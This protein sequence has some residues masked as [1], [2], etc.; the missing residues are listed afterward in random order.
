[1][2]HPSDIVER[3]EELRLFLNGEGLLGGLSFSQAPVRDGVARPY[4]WRSERLPVLTEAADLITRLERERDEARDIVA[5]CNNSLFGSQGYFIEASGKTAAS[6]IEDLKSQTGKGYAA[7]ARV[8]ELEEALRPFAA[9]CRFVSDAPD[10]VCLTITTTIG[11]LRKA[12]AALR[13]DGG[14]EP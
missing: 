6:A 1:M 5:D 2:T 11:E 7:D 4:W 12:R 10:T 9:H 13:L 14:G 8:R 3:L